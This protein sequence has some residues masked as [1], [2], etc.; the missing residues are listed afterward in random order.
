[1]SYSTPD[2]V[3]AAMTPSV[4]VQLTDD[5]NGQT[6]VDTVC[7]SVI[8]RMDAKI[9]TYIAGR[10]IVPTVTNP[11]LNAWSIILTIYGLHT[12][13]G[14]WATPENVKTD[15]DEAIKQL[16]AV[17]EGRA[18]V[19]SLARDTKQK[20]I[21]ISGTPFFTPDEMIGFG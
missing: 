18:V 11:T 9:N 15:Y 4:Y 16:E 3:F 7:Q 19:P 8:D 20:S 1:M 6:R 14:K 17:Y 21:Y 5:D 2:D 12:R 13:R 10:Y